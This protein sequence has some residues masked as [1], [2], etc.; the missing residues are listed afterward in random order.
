M[1]SNPILQ[2]N[3]HNNV[4]EDICCHKFSP[5]IISSIGDD[6]KIIIFDIRSDKIVHNILS[7]E[8]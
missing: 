7:H 1:N 4:I 5:D 8:G 3:H 2:H 6:S